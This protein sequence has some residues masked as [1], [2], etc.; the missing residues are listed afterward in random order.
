M[1]RF[2]YFIELLLFETEKIVVT[3]Q[4]SESFMHR[5]FAS[6]YLHIVKYMFLGLI[7]LLAQFINIYFLPFLR[8]RES[9]Q[10]LE[11]I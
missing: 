6:S 5:Y 1:Q 9:H 3:N 2:N 7:V 10:Y 4:R 11:H 8:E